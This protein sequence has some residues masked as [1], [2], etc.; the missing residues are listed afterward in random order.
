MKIYNYFLDNDKGIIFKD[1]SFGKRTKMQHVKNLKGQ[2]IL[3]MPL[4]SYKIHYAE[5]YLNFIKL[6]N[7]YENI[8]ENIF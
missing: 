4:L 8:K 1:K 5:I 2:K 7:L 6:L 3:I